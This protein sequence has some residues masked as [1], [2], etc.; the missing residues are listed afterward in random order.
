MQSGDRLAALLNGEV[1]FLNADLRD[2][3][4]SRARGATA[5][6]CAAGAT[7]RYPRQLFGQPD[8]PAAGKAET[9]SGAQR[10]R[11]DRTLTALIVDL[12]E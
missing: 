12:I 9:L 8:Q 1:G 2:R 6:E 11:G 3:G 4:C 5:G 7:S 10:L